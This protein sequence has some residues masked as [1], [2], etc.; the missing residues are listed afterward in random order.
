MS[1]LV[2]RRAAM[3]ALCST[4]A[5]VFGVGLVAV[6][7]APLAQSDQ[8]QSA[9]GDPFSVAGGPFV[10]QWGAHGEG[11]TIN[12]D[13]SAVET[14]TSGRVHFRLAFVQGP[15]SQPDT[16]AYGSLPDGGYATAT[17]V[18]G[19]RGLTLSIAGGDDNFPFCKIVD[20]KKVNPAN[21]GA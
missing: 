10:G 6:V 14:T 16:T 5:L 18:D 7:L 1:Y 19:G 3:K 20:G 13:G 8:G 12:A 2:S 17:L 9:L 21:C 11:L 4:G 15:P